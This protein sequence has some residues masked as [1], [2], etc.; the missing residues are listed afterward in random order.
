LVKSVYLD[1]PPRS[2]GQLADWVKGKADIGK[3]TFG[4][5]KEKYEI[6]RK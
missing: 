6:K 2:D 1:E 3:T 5:V 4:Y